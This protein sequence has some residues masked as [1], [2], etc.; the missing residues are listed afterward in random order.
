M[1]ILTSTWKGLLAIGPKLQQNHV[2]QRMVKHTAAVTI[3]IIIV[4]IPAVRNLYGSSSY[5]AAMTAVFGHC[6]Q[7]FGQMAESLV[8]V[9]AG[10]LLGLGWSTLGLYLSSLVFETNEPAA[11]TIRALFLVMVTIV[12]GYVRSHSPRLFVL[13]WLFLLT[14]LTNLVGTASH[15]T[16][17]TATQTL[18]PILTAMGVLLVVNVTVFPEFSGRFLADT[19]IQTLSQTQTTLKTATEWFMEPSS[20]DE[21]ASETNGSSSRQRSNSVAAHSAKSASTPP[22]ISKLATLTGAK[23]K[24]R[25]KLSNCKSALRECMFEIEY[26]V[27]PSR[28]LKPISSTAMAGL[29][30]NVTTLISACESKFVMMDGAGSRGQ[31]SAVTSDTEREESGLSSRTENGERSKTRQPQSIPVSRRTSMESRLEHVKPQREIASGDPEVLDTLLARVREPVTDLLDQINGA[32]PL[33]MTCIAYCYDV[34]QLPPGIIVPK[35]L[36]L[37]EVD[38]RVDVFADA[39]ALFDQCFQEALGKVAAVEAANGEVD[40]MPRIET[41]LLSS[42][43]LSLRQAAEQVTQMLTHARELVGRRQ[44]RNN[45]R[46]LYWP[47]KINWQRWLRS[48][49]EQD[50]MTLPENARKAA[51][52]GNDNQKQSNKH[53]EDADHSDSEDGN[54]TPTKKDEEATPRNQSIRIEEP[55][56]KPDPRNP[57][58][59][60][61]LSSKQSS[62]L[63]WRSQ[64]ADMTETT[65]HSEHLAYALKLTVA[66][67]AIAWIPFYGPFN[68]WFS[69]MRGMWAP[70]QLVLVFEVAIGS[71]FWIF[72]VRAF[73]VIFGCVWGYASYEIS[74]GHLVPLVVILVPGII[75]STYVQLGTPYVKAGMISIVSMCI[76]ALCTLSHPTSFPQPLANIM[77]QQ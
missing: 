9:T 52:Q 46:R 43:L 48:G 15:V 12:H 41:F 55:P 22:T 26:A 68:A 25:A 57:Y 21:E 36:N 61:P 39:I 42:S 16:V 5:L 17:S 27:I 29:I 60:K 64:I 24:L 73:G 51:R 23:A 18:Y 7:R 70:L 59:P 69:S 33:V 66:V 35:G 30:R 11:Y 10:M 45:R 71:S 53:K 2:W 54:A 28:S 1:D 76:V 4:V 75:I 8:M 49:G 67:M 56:A 44:A 34:K 63:R 65:L 62:P 13:V 32:I 47:R 3:T 50:A 37:E 40:I 19:T 74:R 31:E 77:K 20:R 14:S 72:F 38:I 6:A 58:T